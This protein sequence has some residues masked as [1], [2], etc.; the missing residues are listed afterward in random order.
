MSC[1]IRKH[2]TS[3]PR[4]TPLNRRSGSVRGLLPVCCSCCSSQLIIDPRI[5]TCQLSP[6]VLNTCWD[7]CCAHTHVEHGVCVCVC[8][9]GIQEVAHEWPHVSAPRRTGSVL[10]LQL[11]FVPDTVPPSLLFVSLSLALAIIPLGFTLIQ[12]DISH[13]PLMGLLVYNSPFSLLR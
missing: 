5:T 7:Q 1:F 10:Q 6:C 4:P 9:I 13:G 2:L 8:E 3:T 12:T 11:A